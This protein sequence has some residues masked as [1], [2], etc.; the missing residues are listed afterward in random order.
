MQAYYTVTEKLKD[1][2]RALENVTTVSLGDISEVDLN[3][4][5]IFPLAHIVVTNCDLQQRVSVFDLSILFT[6]VVDYNTIET[7]EQP[8]PFYG[9]NNL[10][11]VHNTQLANANLIAQSVRR[12]DLFGDRVQIIGDAVAEPF[13]D[14]FE[15]TLAGWALNMTV[16]IPDDTSIC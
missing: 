4:R 11:D 15:N 12:G 9:N 2:L 3:K 7:K 10:Q 14:R 1:A 6:D 13:Q 5:T 16:A 8:E